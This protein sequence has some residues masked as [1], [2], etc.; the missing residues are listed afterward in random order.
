MEGRYFLKTGKLVPLSAQNI[1]DC[2]RHDDNAGCEGG[3]VIPAFEYIHKND[4]I[5]DESHYPYKEKRG[6]CKY[7]DDY[8]VTSIK[9]YG[10]VEEGK[11]LF[12]F[13]TTS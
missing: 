6:A 1:L 13:L 10:I 4:G 8:N 12:L 11:I 5:D 2:S 9:A 7:S 3:D